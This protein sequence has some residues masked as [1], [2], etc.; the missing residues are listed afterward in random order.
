[1][2][3]RVGVIGGGQLAW[4]M[5]AEAKDLGLELWLQT[6]K[7]GDPAVV[8]ADRAILADLQDIE[9]TDKLA[10]Y[11]DVVTFENEFV[12]LEALGQLAAKGANFRPSLS[13]LQPLLDKYDQRQCCE[14]FGMPVPHYRMWSFGDRLP[15]GWSFPVVI[16][17]RR[18]GYDGKGTFVIQNQT[19]L[20]ALPQALVETPLLIEEFVPFERELA[21]MVARNEVG[22]TR[23]FPVTETQ[24]I[25]QVCRWTITPAP[26]NEAIASQTQAI[27]Q[28]LAEGLDLVGIMGIELFLTTDGKILVNEIAPRTHNSGHFSLNA[29]HTSQFAMQLQAIA[30][31]PLGNPNLKVQGA[32]MVNL[33]GFEKSDSDYQEKR[34]QLAEM[35]DSH[36]HWYGKRGSSPGRK[37]GHVTILSSSNN[38]DH[39]VAIAE[40]VERLWYPQG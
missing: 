13:F 15:E 33:L 34:Q 31:L 28:Q 22:E 2:T 7:Q 19:E 8:R 25:N 37:L 36:V 39:L 30:G 38:R 9:A 17:A 27:A 11:C 1:M 35:T 4:M 18:H 23:V 40:T 12:D 3:Q 14:R 29:C 26:I 20:T 10:H 6:P 21:V 5:G 32:V 24:Q 16:K